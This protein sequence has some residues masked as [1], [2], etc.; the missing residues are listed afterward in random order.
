MKKPEAIVL[1]A[2]LALSVIGRGTGLHKRAN[3][4]HEVYMAS[5]L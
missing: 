4:L 2:A 1:V 5:W 3:Q